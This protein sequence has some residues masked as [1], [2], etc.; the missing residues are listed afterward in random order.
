MSRPEAPPAEAGSRTEI[1]TLGAGCYWCVEAVYQQVEG[2]KSVRSGFMGGE[3]ENP[4]YEQVCSGLTGHAEVVEISFDPAVVTYATIL[5]WFF[6][7]HDPT[8]LN[9]QGADI[10]S[11]YR[12]VIFWH[13][14]AQKAA[15]E[16]AIAALTS[17][18][19]FAGPIVT[20][21]AEASTFYAAKRDHQDYFRQ[22][23]SNPYCQRVIAPKLEKLGL[24]R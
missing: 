18:R 8:T 10:G 1:A 6:R 15:A 4:S 12:S 9:R 20:E 22:N 19:A 23:R 24:R 14:A 3:V 5:D 7:L 16:A 11:Q 13:S 17:S 2:V 21:V